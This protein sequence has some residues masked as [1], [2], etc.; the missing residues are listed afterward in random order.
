MGNVT[1][2]NVDNVW[3]FSLATSIDLKRKMFAFL[4]PI[5]SRINV[6]L[7]WKRKKEGKKNNKKEVS[8]GAF[9]D[10]RRQGSENTTVD[11][12]SAIRMNY[13]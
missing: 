4:S 7:M 3:I 8:C 12:T 11:S 9:G 13:A 1:F 2:P 10:R 6:S 5:D